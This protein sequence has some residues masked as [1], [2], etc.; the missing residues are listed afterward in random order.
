[1]GGRIELLRGAI[2]IGWDGAGG[3]QRKLRELPPVQ[4][5]GSNALVRELVADGRGS[6]L[7]QRGPGLDLQHLLTAR[8]LQCQID[9]RRLPDL[10]NQAMQEARGKAGGHHL[11][12]VGPYRYERKSIEPLLIGFGFADLPCG[13]VLQL[14]LGSGNDRATGIGNEPFQLAVPVLRAA[15]PRCQGQT[16][17]GKENF[18]DEND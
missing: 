18:E 6:R 5:K 8:E 2:R 12:V 11:Q 13:R 10:Q 14:N 3:E 1:M 7:D 9:A 4:G 17:Q 16:A 15:R